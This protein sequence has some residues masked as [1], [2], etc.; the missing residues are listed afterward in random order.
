V[1]YNRR[2]FN[3]TEI[4]KMYNLIPTYEEKV[5]SL[6]ATLAMMTPEEHARFGAMFEN[7]L[8]HFEKLVADAE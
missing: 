3:E 2:T 5:Q 4:N 6:K 7:D 8:K 1:S